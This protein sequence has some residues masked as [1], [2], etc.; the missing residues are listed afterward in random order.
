M[1]GFPFPKHEDTLVNLA[2]SLLKRFS[3]DPPHPT[4]PLADS[5]LA[6]NFRHVAL[7]VLDGMGSAVLEQHLPEDGFFRSHMAGNIAS[8]FPPTTVAATTALQCGL[9]PIET[10]WLGWEC[11]FPALDKNVVYFRNA[12][13]QGNP[14]P[15]GRTARDYYPIA[16]ICDRIREAGFEGDIVSPFVPP[17]PGDFA[18]LCARIRELC[19]KDAPG[20]IY[21]YWPEPDHLLHSHGCAGAAVGEALR[22]REAQCALLAAG[23]KDTLLLITADHGHADCRGAMITDYP[24]LWECLEKPPSI[25]PR[26]MNL[27]V[28]ASHRPRFEALF[29]SLFGDVYT[30]IPR[31]E[32]LDRSLFGLG[33]PGENVAAML[34]DY[35]AVATGDFTLYYT[36]KDRARFKSTHGGLTEAEMTVPLIAVPCK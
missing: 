32:F 6:G 19:L 12:D 30:L 21:A 13:R 9:F 10:G 28:K 34:G 29:Q 20:F 36:E 5:L 25:E 2:C 22:E 35:I 24:E 15:D 16:H 7:L 31:K 27:F 26:A 1:T 33:N 8:T 14:L 11:H 23:L 17:C 4:L 18:G 3:L